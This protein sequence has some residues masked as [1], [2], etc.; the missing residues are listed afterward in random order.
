MVKKDEML[1]ARDQASEKGKPRMEPGLRATNQ[2]SRPRAIDQASKIGQPECISSQKEPGLRAIDQASEKGEPPPREPGLRARDQASEKGQLSNILVTQSESGNNRVETTSNIEQRVQL[3]NRAHLMGHFGYDSMITSLIQQGHYWLIMK[4]ESE[5]ICQD[6]I[7]C[8]RFNISKAGYHPMK[9]IWAILPIDHLALDLKEYPLS[10]AGQRYCLVIIDICTRFVWLHALPNKEASTVAKALW[11]TISNFGLPKIIQSDNGTEFVNKILKELVKASSIDHGLITAYHARAN[12]SAERM[13]QTSSQSVYK[14]LEGRI[15][16][17]DLHLPAVQLFINM[18]VS[19]RH[20]STPY[21]LLFARNPNQF[22]NYD[23]TPDTRISEERLLERLQYINNIV[24]P[25]VHEKTNATMQQYKIQFDKNHLM[26]NGKFTNG[27]LVMCKNELRK[28]KD[29]ERF[30]GP[31]KVKSRNTNGT[32]LL[33]DAVGTEFARAPSALKL[34]KKVTNLDA[35][36]VK[37]IH[38]ERQTPDGQWEYLTEFKDSNN[39]LR[40]WIAGADFHDLSPIREFVKKRKGDA[41]ENQKP[42]KGDATENQKPPKRV[43]FLE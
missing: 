13:V 17:W 26:I 20:G 14:V 34:I 37:Q 18:K 7:A 38:E 41:T 23:K 19:R 39:T 3:L 35:G 11:S 8:Q 21:S 1:R 2:A 24:Y 31:F 25:A 30:T 12:G 22:E 32:Y 40:Q 42:P 15:V 43:K 36:E 5:Q 28:S 9:T 6:C 10:S 29:E 33:V 27:S 16:E 4:K